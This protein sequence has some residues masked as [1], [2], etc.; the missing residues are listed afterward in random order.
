MLSSRFSSDVE[1]TLAAAL[2]VAAADLSQ[3][4]AISHS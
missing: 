2:K 3:Q 4:A 1:D